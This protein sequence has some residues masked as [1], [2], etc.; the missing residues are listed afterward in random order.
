MGL[1]EKEVRTVA[2]NRYFQKVKWW[3]WGGAIVVM[4][5]VIAVAALTDGGTPVKSY[6]NLPDCG[7]LEI[8]GSV[9]S[10]DGEVLAKAGSDKSTIDWTGMGICLGIFVVALLVAWLAFAR[11]QDRYTKQFVEKWKNT[12]EIPGD[13][14]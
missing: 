5:A 9:V 11:P 2:M 1:T 13:G 12:G 8:S 14:K 6:Y 10:V 4:V 7:V 3:F